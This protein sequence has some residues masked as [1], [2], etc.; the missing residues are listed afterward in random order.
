[1]VIF[2]KMCHFCQKWPKLRRVE[3]K[4]FFFWGHF[5]PTH[6]LTHFFRPSQHGISHIFDYDLL[7]KMT[8]H[9]QFFQKWPKSEKRV[10]MAI[11]EGEQVWPNFLAKFPKMTTFWPLF[12]HFFTTFCKFQFR[13]VNFALFLTDLF[14]FRTFLKHVILRGSKNDLFL[15]NTTFFQKSTFFE[16]CFYT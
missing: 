10:K 3:K 13:W 15:K 4:H 12:L 7:G 5:W 6:F 9:G 1:M 16:P 8:P 11:L 2:S 14:L